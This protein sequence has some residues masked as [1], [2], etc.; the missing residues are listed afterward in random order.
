MLA[1]K[2]PRYGS[3]LISFSLPVTTDQV[4]AVAGDGTAEC[5]TPLDHRPSLPSNGDDV[6]SVRPI[7]TVQFEQLTMHLQIQDPVQ[8]GVRCRPTFFYWYLRRRKFSRRG[9]TIYHPVVYTIEVQSSAILH[10]WP[11]ATGQALLGIKLSRYWRKTRA[12]R[13]QCRSVSNHCIS[14]GNGCGQICNKVKSWTP[15]PNRSILECGRSSKAL[16]SPTAAS[17]TPLG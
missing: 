8:A 7:R 6:R 3:R 10:Y 17:G 11:S 2:M 13:S 4:F 14:R 9:R 12:G 5:A 15:K 16:G 1:V